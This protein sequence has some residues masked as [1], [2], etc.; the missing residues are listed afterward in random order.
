MKELVWTIIQAPFR[1]VQYVSKI[2]DVAVPN[3]SSQ[4][5]CQNIFEKHVEYLWKDTINVFWKEFHFNNY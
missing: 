2:P 1:L 3:Y 5:I 4:L